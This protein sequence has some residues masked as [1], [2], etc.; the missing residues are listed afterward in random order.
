LTTFRQKGQLNNPAWLSNPPFFLPLCRCNTPKLHKKEGSNDFMHLTSFGPFLRILTCKCPKR[1]KK[2]ELIKNAHLSIFRPFLLV[3]SLRQVNDFNGVPDSDNPR[4]PEMC[5]IV[6]HVLV[7]VGTGG[8]MC[9]GGWLGV[10]GCFAQGGHG[11]LLAASPPLRIYPTTY[12]SY[13]PTPSTCVSVS[14]RT[15]TE[16]HT[17][18]SPESGGVV[19]RPSA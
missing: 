5:L 7:G 15:T 10:G 8:Y 3:C 13:L 18:V 9:K 11:T 16:W 17:H 2:E 19:D 4:I 1:A 14:T 12:P 6:V